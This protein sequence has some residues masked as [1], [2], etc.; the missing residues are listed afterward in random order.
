MRLFYW[1][2]FLLWRPI[3]WSPGKKLVYNYLKTMIIQNTHLPY[4]KQDP[5]QVQ[6]SHCG[7]SPGV[8]S[9]PEDE[10]PVPQRCRTPASSWTALVMTPQSSPPAVR[11][12][13]HLHGPQSSWAERSRERWGPSPTPEKRQTGFRHESLFLTLVWDWSADQ[14]IINQ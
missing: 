2:I 4:A 5:W 6:E 7:G 3:C 11:H 12:A 13:S 1:S 14:S 10:Q 9:G 8:G